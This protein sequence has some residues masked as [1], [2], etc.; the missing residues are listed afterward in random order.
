ME[1]EMSTRHRPTMPVL[2]IQRT[3]GG[4]RYRLQSLK[5]PTSQFNKVIRRLSEPY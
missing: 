3:L 2:V 4:G 5:L 1:M